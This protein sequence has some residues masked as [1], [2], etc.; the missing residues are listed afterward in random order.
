MQAEAV[1]PLSP[2]GAADY[3]PAQSPLQHAL[4]LTPPYLFGPAWLRSPW[5]TQRMMPPAPVASS[6]VVRPRV[7]ES[8]PA[9]IPDHRQPFNAAIPAGARLGPVTSVDRTINR[10]LNRVGPPTTRPT[11][12]SFPSLAPVLAP[13]TQP[14]TK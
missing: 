10:P 4:G 1:G 6:G 8:E 11:E 13:A 2:N 9:A 14:A 3:I 5:S 7:E 12:N